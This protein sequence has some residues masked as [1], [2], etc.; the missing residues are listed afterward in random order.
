MTAAESATALPAPN[1]RAH[2][3]MPELAL[4]TTISLWSSTFVVTKDQLDRFHPMAF[5]FV[6]FLLM[7]TMAVVIMVIRERG[8]PLPEKR[9]L[10][11]FVATGITG[12]TIYQLGFV[13]S[14][15][16]TSVFASSLLIATSPLFTMV[17]LSLIGE[18]S[19]W[20]SWVGL[21]IAVVG[22][23]L[24][25]VDKRGG[26]RSLSGD[27]L[28]IMAAAS[29]AAYGI[30]NRPL[31]RAYPPATYTAWA[32]TFGTIPLLIAGLPQAMDQNWTAIPASSWLAVLYMVI[33]PVYVAYMLWN[34][35]IKHRGA[36]LASSFGLL[37]PILSGLLSVAFF[38]ER[39]GVIKIAGAALA[40][41]GLLIIRVGAIRAST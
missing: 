8:I 31:A 15:D 1:R 9:H 22:I 29:F 13:L 6:R 20:L 4:L 14:L 19:P 38:D 5:I 18:K 7:M 33:F 2:S 32:V 24:F 11:Q 36:A 26:E 39:F 34:F 16:R 41:A 10:W 28:A 21:G 23:A 30:I 17:F 12:Y 25:L 27:L 35:G 3:W 40:L 37:V